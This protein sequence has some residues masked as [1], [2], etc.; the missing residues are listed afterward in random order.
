MSQIAELHESPPTY[1][2]FEPHKDSGQK[3]R[4][5][6]KGVRS[7]LQEAVDIKAIAYQALKELQNSIG[8]S[9]EQEAINARAMAQAVTTLIKGWETG[10]EAIR[11]ARGKPL[12]GSLRPE[13]KPKR[14]KVKPSMFTESKPE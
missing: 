6:R 3:A 11:I 13:A 1:G 4:A 2:Q 12:P 8:S 10:V 7:I 9:N 14:G 5:I